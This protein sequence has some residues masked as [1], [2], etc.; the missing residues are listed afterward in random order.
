[1][2]CATLPHGSSPRVRGTGFQRPIP[3][4]EARFIPARAGNSTS[5]SNRNRHSAVHPRACG[6]QQ[7]S[8][9]RRSWPAGSSPRVR[10]TGQRLHRHRRIDRFIPARAGNRGR[11]A[12]GHRRRPVHPRAC[13]EQIT[14]IMGEVTSVGSSPRVRGTGVR[15]GRQGFVGRFIPA[16]A[17]NSGATDRS[18][19]RSAVHPRACGEQ[20]ACR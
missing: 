18:A 12:A 7:L 6:E 15:L 19:H 1:M 9:G 3:S 4:V 10:G 11:G 5:G 20:T 14:P 17:G 16:R 13:G 2:A 8:A